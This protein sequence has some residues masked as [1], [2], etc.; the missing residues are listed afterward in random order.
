M[1][2]VGG[3]GVTTSRNGQWVLCLMHIR[4]RTPGLILHISI[5]CISGE[6]EGF[7]SEAQADALSI[8]LKTPLFNM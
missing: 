5:T 7:Y 3:T 4:M 1:L 2:L 8:F 6:M